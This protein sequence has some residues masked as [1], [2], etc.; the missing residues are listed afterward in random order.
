VAVDARGFSYVVGE[1]GSR[2]FPVTLGARPR[3]VP[4]C[5]FIAKLSPAGA[6][7]WAR[8]LGGAR[9]T[10][11]RAVAVDARGRVHV[12]GATNS[13]DSP[14]TRDAL[15]RSYGG[16]P[17]DAFY[18]VLSS[19]GWLVYSTFLGDAHY[20]EANAVAVDRRGRAVLTGRTVSPR[21]PRVGSLRPRV[22]GGAFVARFDG[23][24]LDYSTVFGGGDKGNH[25]NAGFAVA[26]GRDGA[27]YVTG[28]TNAATFPRTR[29]FQARLGGGGDAFVLAIDGRGRRVLYST[30]LGGSGDDAGRAIAVGASGVWVAGVTASADFPGARGAGSGFLAR[31]S[32]AGAA[33]SYLAA[34]VNALALGDR[35]YASRSPGL[36]VGPLFVTA[37]RADDDA[38][39][40]AAETLADDAA[41]SRSS[42]AASR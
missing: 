20:D 10:S 35:P 25:G 36:A 17:F 39:V 7:V 41:G 18:A 5:A 14:T 4:I 31:V 8:A 3:G 30:F 19:D 28:V 11:A 33:T 22:A 9:Y 38:V 16:G 1:T 26:V 34:D 24:R 2:D 15:A 40:T 21:F 42:G 13:T 27:A 37:G 29:A 32:P 6:V 12:V 23:P